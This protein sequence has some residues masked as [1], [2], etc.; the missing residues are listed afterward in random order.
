MI[1]DKRR[2]DCFAYRGCRSKERCSALNELYCQNEHCTFFKTKE[3][4]NDGVRK[5]GG[6]GIETD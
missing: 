2:P 6:D 5:Y 4:F 3:E 1:E